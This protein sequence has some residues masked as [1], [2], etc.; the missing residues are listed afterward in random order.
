MTSG[1]VWCF[2]WAGAAGAA[3]A[4][5]GA[6]GAAGAAGIGAG[7]T[8]AAG[9]AGA[10]GVGGAGA[11]GADAGD[12]FCHVDAVDASGV[13]AL[14]L[15]SKHAHAEVVELLLGVLRLDHCATNNDGKTAFALAKEKAAAIKEGAYR[16]EEVKALPALMSR[17]M[18][19]KSWRLLRLWLRVKVML[20]HWLVL[21][22][23][24]HQELIR[25]AQDD[26]AT[27]DLNPNNP[28]RRRLR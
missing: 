17:W 12:S 24:K 16:H 14:M 5:A 3:G 15:A 7:A 25:L 20:K 18:A 13:S 21:P 4:G 27:H 2:G 22:L 9:A 23:R 1:L 6:A 19:A 28:K 11:G 26:W 10:T 8:G